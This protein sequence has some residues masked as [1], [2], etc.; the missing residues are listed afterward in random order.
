MEIIF[1]WD[2]AKCCHLLVVR[3]AVGG[4]ARTGLGFHSEAPGPV[5]IWLQKLA[6][7]RQAGKEEKIQVAWELWSGRW[8]NR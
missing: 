3:K 5:Q 4:E 7:D 6:G 2:V 1:S 8:E